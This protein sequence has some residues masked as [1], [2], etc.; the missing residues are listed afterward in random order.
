MTNNKLTYC[1]PLPLP[2]IMEGHYDTEKPDFVR[3]YRCVAD[4]TVIFDDGVWYMY[5]TSAGKIFSSCDGLNWR[6]HELLGNLE[7]SAPAITKFRG[8]Y[9]FALNGCNFE[10]FVADTPISEFKSLGN[11][12]TAD[13]EIVKI[14]DP[15]FLSDEDEALY[16]YWGC[17]SDELYAAKLSNDDPTLI[18]GEIKTI[19]KFNPENVWERWGTYNHGAY[20]GWVEGGHMYKKNGKYYLVYSAAGTEFASYAMGVYVSD[21]PIGDF[22]YQDVNPLIRGHQSIVRGCGHGCVVDGPNDTIWVF[23]TCI[24]SCFHKFER[25][26]GMDRAFIDDNGNLVCGSPTGIPQFGPVVADKD[27]KPCE[28]LPL[29]AENFP[30]VSSNAQGSEPVYLCDESPKS[31][32]RPESDDKEPWVKHIIGNYFEVSAAR[33]VW[34][35]AYIDYANGIFAEPVSYVIEGIDQNN[36]KIILLDASENQDEI[37]CDYRE[38]EPKIC[39]EI[40]LRF[41][42][43]EKYDLGIVDFTVYGKAIDS[44]LVPKHGT[45]YS[46]N[47]YSFK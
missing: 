30:V 39:K 12:H 11:V 19:I 13:G 29:T 9:Y 26:I 16:V 21:S 40:T 6:S 45:G 35:E 5:A 10:L 7:G 46:P 17:G 18:E 22:K 2:D 47:Y 38:F 15:I 32:W 25:R 3:H 20:K 4:C 37:N 41:K 36:N 44:S 28:L 24:M 34:K 8:K 23:Y 14:V 27:L 42:K 43:P 1:N 33:I 31:W